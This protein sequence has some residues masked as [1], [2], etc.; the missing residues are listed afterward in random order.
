V[1]SPELASIGATWELQI[2]GYRALYDVEPATQVLI[3]RVIHKGT[4]T[5]VEALRTSNTKEEDE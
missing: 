4:L 1:P 5:L 2:G 3:I